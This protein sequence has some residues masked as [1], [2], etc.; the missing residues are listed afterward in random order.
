V[1]TGETIAARLRE[2][3]PGLECSA[4]VSCGDVRVEVPRER[5]V[6]V[7][8]FLRTAPGLEFGFLI[9]LTAVDWPGQRKRFE[10]VYQL[11][12][13]TRNER[14][15]VTCRVPETDCKAPTMTAVWRGANWLERE[16]FDLMGI[17]FEGHPD[18]RRIVLPQAFRGHP[19]RKEFPLRGDESVDPVVD[20]AGVLDT[21]TP[22]ELAGA[23][24][25]PR[26]ETLVINMGPQHPSTHGVLRLVLTLEGETVI[27]C[28]PDIGFLHTGME[29]QSESEKYYQAICSTDRMDY[30]SPM[31]NNLAYCLT[32]E[33]LMGVEVPERAQVLRVLLCEL[34]RIASHL[35]W[36]G[37]HAMDIGAMT[38]FLYC[39]RERE[40]IMD[41]FGEIAG[42]RITPSFICVGGLY[43]D[44][45]ERFL[46]M[47]RAFARDFPACMADYVRLL[48][49]NPIFV[50]RTQG[51]GYMSQDDLI[52]WGVTGPMLRA[53]GLAWDLRKAQPYT[54][55]DRFDFDIPTET[56][57]DVYAR[58]LVRLEEMRQSLRIVEQA[59]GGLPGGPTMSEDRRV[60]WPDRGKVRRDMH[61]LIH[62]FKIVHEGFSP[63]PGAAYHGIE[64]PKGE[65]GFYMVSDG[66][67]HP[68]RCRVRPPSFVNLQSLP[69][70][71]S[72]A[73][74]ADVVAAIGSID[75]VLG[76][77]DR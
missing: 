35:V 74:V 25:D 65:L 52:D 29:K 8:R 11:L 22:P 12:S 43:A 33:K 45:T 31:T 77:V 4:S 59:L 36:L 38:V 2:A 28:M 61:A 21:P 42:G 60:N 17:R 20:Y 44:A 41:A 14:L 46:E 40:R 27:G 26:N 63:P 15:T 56:A 51:V 69:Q 23:E 57:S 1:T 6:D 48:S 75:I 3:L 54:G 50:R 30:L 71:V 72:G 76:E 66:G 9:D 62:H 58:Y 32:V 53:S 10:L 49:K 73:F 7:C 16:V 19:L 34:S 39:F 13:L 68:Y 70:M 5:I 55:Y 18:L 67:P 37:T 24:H 47:A 64:G